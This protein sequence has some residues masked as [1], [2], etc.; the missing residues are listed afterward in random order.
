ML[1]KRKVKLRYNLRKS[2]TVT[3]S[4]RLGYINGAKMKRD[5]GNLMIVKLG[6]DTV[7]KM[8]I[9]KNTNNC[10]NKHTV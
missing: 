8:K 10:V 4:L 7:I 2:I 1:D 6:T 9:V 5:I 3:I